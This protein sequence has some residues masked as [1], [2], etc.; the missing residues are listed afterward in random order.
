M[1]FFGKKSTVE[2][3]YVDMEH[4][5]V[6][7][8]IA[9]AVVDEPRLGTAP[10]CYHDTNHFVP[11]IV[12][13]QQQQRLYTA[14]APP[15]PPKRSSPGHTILLQRALPR[16]PTVLPICSNC[17]MSPCPT[18]VR[19][20]PSFVTCVLAVILLLVFWPICW[21]PFVMDTTKKTDHFCKAC[22]AQ[23]GD[24]EPLQDCCVKH[25]T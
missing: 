20:A 25:R 1:G 3:D 14:I 2:S 10:H 5:A 11:P 17:Q 24:V 4:G 13:Q 19:T 7:L 8:P 9:V 6:D 21:L 18:R 15:P 22:N 12:Q 16:H 23:V